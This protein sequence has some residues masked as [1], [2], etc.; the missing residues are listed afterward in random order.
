MPPRSSWKRDWGRLLGSALAP[1][2]V[3]TR[4]SIHLLR[5]PRLPSSNASIGRGQNGRNIIVK[6]Q[7][8]LYCN[9]SDCELS[10]AVEPFIGRYPNNAFPILE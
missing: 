4:P 3:V 10:K 7:P 1:A 6:R 9:G 5:P 2:T 8:P